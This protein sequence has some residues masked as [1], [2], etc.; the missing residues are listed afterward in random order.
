MAVERPEQEVIPTQTY[1]GPIGLKAY[2]NPFNRRTTIE[3]TLSDLGE[4]SLHLFD[5][6]GS[7]LRTIESAIA[8]DKGSHRVELDATILA[9][10]AYMLVVQQV[11]VRESIRLI[12]VR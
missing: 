8:R 10:G 12:I 4:V 1:P 7:R 5:L 9:A 11:G 6:F 2:P 3:Y